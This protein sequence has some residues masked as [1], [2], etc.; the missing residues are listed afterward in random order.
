MKNTFAIA[1]I[2]CSSL[3]T[4]CAT[5]PMASVELD[6]EAKTFAVEPGKA[7]I[8]VYRNETMGAAVAMPV[9]LDG[10]VAGKTASKTYFMWT[11]EPGMHEITS[12]TENTSKL[13]IDA[14]AGQ[15]HFVW[16]EVKMGAWSARSLLQEVSEEEG[17]KGVLECKLIQSEI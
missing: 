17:R 2:F 3:L 14:R 11:V 5:V 9:A 8:Y 1:F 6:Q 4:G 12:L 7:N 10:R 13:S 16:Q 15:N